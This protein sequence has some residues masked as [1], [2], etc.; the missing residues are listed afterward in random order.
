MKSKLTKTWVVILLAGICCMLWGSA[1]PC[2]K[3]GY[4]LFDIASGE[5]YSQILFAGCRFALAGIMVIITFSIISRKFIKPSNPEKIV[6]LSLFQTVIQYIPFYIGL[7]HTTGVKSSIM[8]GTGVFVT[9]LVACVIFKQEKMTTRKIVGSLLGFIG[10]ALVNMNGAAL[11][12]NISFLGEGMIMLSIIS[13]AFSSS[14]IKRFSKN[15]NVVML[16]GYQFLVGGLV[17]AVVG[18]LL[19]GK[20][21]NIS[22]Q[23][24]LLLLYMAFISAAAYTIW[25]ILLKYNSVSK[26]SAYKFMNP[27]FGAVLSFVILKESNQFG[28]NMVIALVL[29]CLGIY[30]V[31]RPKNVVK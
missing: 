19:G 29:I 5:F 1:F 16:S 11:D 24:V 2:I 18:L 30:I 31:N 4:K 17:M 15:A 7:A 8:N 12:G 28:I 14:F 22:I 20:L 6:V 10:V 23:S 21:E 9:I 27:V 3:T 13:S 26:V 25:S